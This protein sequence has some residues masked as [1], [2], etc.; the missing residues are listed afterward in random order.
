MQQLRG[1]GALILWLACSLPVLAV[2]DMLALRARP[3]AGVHLDVGNRGDSAVLTQVFGQEEDGQ[4]TY[5]WTGAE[6]AL[7]VHNFPAVPNPVLTLAIG[8]LPPSAPAPRPVEVR[9]N[10]TPWLRLDV[11]AA[12]RQYH[13]VL[14]PAALQS[15]DL[16]VSLVGPTSQVPP[17]PRDVGVRLDDLA[18]T[19]ADGTLLLSGWRTI[20]VQWVLVWIG[21][22]IAA[23]IGVSRLAQFGVVIALVLLLAVFN[24]FDPLVSHLWQAWLVPWTFALLVLVVLFRPVI[25]RAVPGI[26]PAGARILTSIAALAIAIRLIGVCYPQFGT[27]DLSVHRFRLQ[28]I[29][30]GTL[31]LFDKPSEFARGTTVVPPAFYLLVQPFTLLPA[32]S[33]LVLDG[34]LAILDG[35]SV[36]LVAALTRSL[37]GSERAALLAGV[38]VAFLP[39]QLSALWWGFSPQ[40]AGQ[41]LLVL[42]V[43]VGA[44]QRWPITAIL[45]SLVLMSHPGVALLGGV[46]LAGY[47]ALLWLFD[48]SKRAVWQPWAAT[49]VLGA[50]LAAILLYADSIVG[51]LSGFSNRSGGLGR[52]DSY[53]RI[54]EIGKGLVESVRPL[55]LPLACGSLLMAVLATR[56]AQRRL[57]IAWIGSAL[58]FLLVD[59]ATGL[60]V[61]YMYFA[62]PVLCAG[63]A[64]ILDRIMQRSWW[65]WTAA[66]CTLALICL[67][68][69]SLWAGGTLWDIK[70]TLTALTH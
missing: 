61:R 25:P 69:L 17:D 60:Q 36:V 41:W 67:A 62:V 39:V 52:P 40:V 51:Y 57:V 28:Q 34:L 2:A 50:A 45:F 59:L 19:W 56:T 18:L 70:P 64:Q 68:G 33:G 47:V 14:P 54:A 46:W 3:I 29:E 58:L 9:V 27:H 8:G 13:M 55:G 38:L 23:L 30:A 5:R 24:A 48:R 12:P 16:V 1:W 7:V 21:A 22:A 44:R 49:L 20:A 6:S 66:W 31:Y 11:V 26:S 65:G 37:G 53:A 10:A 4:T 63:T 35:T 15:G 32:P 43:V 42:L